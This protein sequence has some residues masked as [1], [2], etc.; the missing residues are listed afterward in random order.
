MENERRWLKNF[1]EGKKP[2]VSQFKL[3]M[4]MESEEVVQAYKERMFD[5]GLHA[6][7]VFS[8]REKA[9]LINF[10]K[11]FRQDYLNYTNNKTMMGRLRYQPQDLE[12]FKMIFNL[13]EQ[14]GIHRSHT[15]Y[16]LLAF[17]L[18]HS[19]DIDMHIKSFAD[20]IRAA[21]PEV[22]EIRDFFALHKIAFAS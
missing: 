11:S 22:G 12:G 14:S 17:C 1:F 15:N 4:Q 6:W 13:V 16:T 9:F 7:E 2:T 5:L 18:L 10:V 20:A 3:K 21:N 8:K 19:F